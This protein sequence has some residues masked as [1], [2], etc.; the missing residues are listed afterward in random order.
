MTRLT[1]DGHGGTSVAIDLCAGCQ[2]FWFEP[3]ESLQLTPASTL[4]VFSR[5]GEDRAAR[6]APLAAVLRCPH[7]AS[8]LVMTHDRQRST[9][10]RYWRC[11]RR[12]GRFITFFEFLREKDF[13]RPLTPVQIA[14]LRQS[15]HVVNCSNCA[16]PIDLANGTVCTHCGSPVSMLDMKQAEQLVTQLRKASEPRPI[17]PALPLELARARRDVEASFASGGGGE[18]WWREASASSLVEA[19]LSAVARWLKKSVP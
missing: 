16:A 10:F 3:R 19:G 2:A 14:E 17:D 18:E 6:K 11:D 15:I 8:R 9:P 13:I 4:A 5:I 1:L 7:C 12:H